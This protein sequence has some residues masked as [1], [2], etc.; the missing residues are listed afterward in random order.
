[1]D[2]AETEQIRRLHE[3]GLRTETFGERRKRLEMMEAEQIRRLHERGLK[4]PQAAAAGDDE[5]RRRL[6]DFRSF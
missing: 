1:M 2:V 4:R 5:K 3:R 6:D